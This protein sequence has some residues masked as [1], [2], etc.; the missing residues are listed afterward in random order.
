MIVEGRPDEDVIQVA[1][2]NLFGMVGQLE[3]TIKTVDNRVERIEEERARER[4]EM[5]R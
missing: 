1:L 2:T 3:A 5:H 4:R